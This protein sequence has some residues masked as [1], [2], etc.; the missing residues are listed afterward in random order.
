[1]EAILAETLSYDLPKTLLNKNPQT[2]IFSFKTRDEL[3]SDKVQ[4]ER[5]GYVEYALYFTSV[6][7]L[8]LDLVTASKVMKPALNPPGLTYFYFTGIG[9][10]TLLLGLLIRKSRLTSLREISETLD[11]FSQK[12]GPQLFLAHTDDF[13][14]GEAHTNTVNPLSNRNADSSV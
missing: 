3:A 11:I 1:M 12:K 4:L 2:K 5:Q 10:A 13:D 8:M 6:A 14:S 7:M 9:I